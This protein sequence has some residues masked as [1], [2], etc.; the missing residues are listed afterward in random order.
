MIF[1]TLL[2]IL[3]F[4]GLAGI[5]TA[6]FPINDQVGYLESTQG[7]IDIESTHVLAKRD[8]YTCYGNTNISIPDCEA[9]FGKIR[10]DGRNQTF[11]LHSGVCLNWSEGT[12]AVRFCAVPYTYKPVNRTSDW[13]ID[14]LTTPLLDNC[15]RG[16]QQGLMG[17][18]PNINGPSGTYRLYLEYHE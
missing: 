5:A 3:A 7:A 10:L 13:L 4:I 16:G 17:D 15:V 6:T 8:A 11:K 12:C 18:H 9:A 2:T 14:Y 1:T